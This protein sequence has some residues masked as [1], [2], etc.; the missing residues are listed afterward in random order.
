ML[1]AMVRDDDGVV[2]SVE[3]EGATVVRSRK[4]RR[5]IQP[6]H[7]AI[8]QS[9]GNTHKI[10]ARTDKMC[11]GTAT[12]TATGTCQNQNKHHAI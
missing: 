10:T 1:T 9:G 4:R 11:S 2:C 3:E 8:R 12:A 7:I 6:V 5:W